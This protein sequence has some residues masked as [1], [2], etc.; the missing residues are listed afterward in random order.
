MRHNKFDEAYCHSAKEVDLVLLDAELE[1]GDVYSPGGVEHDSNSEM[2]YHAEI[3]RYDDGET[4]CFIES[5]T[6]GKA[7]GILNDAGIEIL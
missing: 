3:V 4:V 5:K 1:R 2:P 6:L 7:L